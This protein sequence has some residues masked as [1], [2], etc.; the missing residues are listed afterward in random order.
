MSN[1]ILRQCHYS[2]LSMYFSD[3]DLDLICSGGSL[4]ALILSPEN[5]AFCSPLLSASPRSI[6]LASLNLPRYR[7]LSFA[8]QQ[9]AITATLGGTFLGS[10][11]SGASIFMAPTAAMGFVIAGGLTVVKVSLLLEEVM[12]FCGFVLL[13]VSVFLEGGRERRREDRQ[14][15]YWW[16]ILF[17]RGWEISRAKRCSEVEV[18]ATAVKHRRI[19]GLLPSVGGTLIEAFWDLYISARYTPLLPRD[20]LVLATCS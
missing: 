1:T 16:C 13:L 14:M 6:C 19:A 7:S 17:R 8:A 5:S 15:R 9:G 2:A 4:R 18:N 20:H 12:F 3:D 11:V 10:I